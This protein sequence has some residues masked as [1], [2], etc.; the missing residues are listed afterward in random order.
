MQCSKWRRFGI[1]PFLIRVVS[2]TWSF[3]LHIYLWKA[4]SCFPTQELRS[5]I[6]NYSHKLVTPIGNESEQVIKRYLNFSLIMFISFVITEFMSQM[7]SYNINGS[8]LVFVYHSLLALYLCYMNHSTLIR[9][10]QETDTCRWNQNHGIT[11]F[12]GGR[13]LVIQTVHKQNA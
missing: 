4:V 11:T 12:H 3:T 13:A 1:G 5:S 9:S 8:L 2:A 7:F 6:I 10:W